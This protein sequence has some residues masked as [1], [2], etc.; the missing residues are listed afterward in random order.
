MGSDHTS[1]SGGSLLA[2]GA[3]IA[4]ASIGELDSELG[5]FFVLWERDQALHLLK[6]AS[7]ADAR[8]QARR[9]V[10]GIAD[11]ATVCLESAKGLEHNLCALGREEARL[12]VHAANVRVLE[13]AIFVERN[14]ALGECGLAAVP[15]DERAGEVVG[16][17]AERAKLERADELEGPSALANVLENGV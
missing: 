9:L 6:G 3:H 12:K 1:E 16:H 4:L 14:D 7:E 13:A 2:F 5:C 15:L 11:R 17:R 10:V 8:A